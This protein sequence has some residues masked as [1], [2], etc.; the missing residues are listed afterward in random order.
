MM[1]RA[2]FKFLWPPVGQALP[3]ANLTESRPPAPS[4]RSSVPQFA[5]LLLLFL[6][7]APAPGLSQGEAEPYFSISSNRT[8]PSNGRTAIELSAAHL[9]SLEF[10]IYRIQ[11][12][13][14]FFQQIEDP[15]QFG[16]RVPAPSREPTLL[17]RI[18]SWKRS[19]RVDIRRSLRAQF[20]ES[21]SAH[22]ANALPHQPAKPGD[23]GTYY[24]ETPLLNSQQLV[25]SFVQPVEGH[26]RWD[27]ETVELGIKEKGVYLVEAVRHDLR[28]YT[29]LVVTD[30]VMI[31]KTGKGRIVSLMVDRTTGEPIRDAKLWLL[32]KDGHRQESVTNPEGIGQLRMEEERP[33][34]VRIV[35]QR[36]GD[37][38]INSLASYSFGVNTDEW[39]GYAYTDRPV[40]R[41]GH[42]V[43]FNAIVR[44][45]TASGYEVPA[46]Q[47]LTVEIQDQDQKPVYSKSLTVSAN[48][49]LHGDLVLSPTATLGYYNLQVKGAEVLMTANFEV[50]EYKKPE[51]EVRVL[52]AKARVLQGESVQATID[53]RYYFGEPVAGAK[54]EFAVYRDRYWLPLWYDP[55]EAYSQPQNPDDN[56]SSGDEIAKGDGQ[57]DADGKLSIHVETGVSEH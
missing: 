36:G 9:D 45:R 56:E 52:P 41:P 29:I 46:G 20:S 57:L 7:A 13:V 4:R 47:T 32:Q 42:A 16:G 37:F 38:A 53:S 12:P 6:A 48:G 35:G 15:H 1:M 30:V 8:F 44:L 22:L 5:R 24:A 2:I 11:D 25:H 19:L 33:D 31:T 43:H 50:Q 21:P 17:E 23:R 40:Y 14:K 55:E 18:H 10:R 28:A 39:R 26:S 51:Y 3:P 27:R 34:D 54:V 49:S